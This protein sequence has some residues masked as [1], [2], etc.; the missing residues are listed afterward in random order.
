MFPFKI[1]IFSIGVQLSYRGGGEAAV[2]G[3]RD[4]TSP[5]SEPV[6]ARLEYNSIGFV[7]NAEIEYFI[8]KNFGLG[9]NLNF[10][11]Y[12]FENAKLKG[13][14]TNQPDPLYVQIYKPNNLNFTT[15]FK[16]AYKFSFSKTKH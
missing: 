4:P 2:F 11:Y 14:G 9:V 16:M 1:F 7:P 13:E 3:Y 8:T 6:E 15:T 5:L 10:N 12:P